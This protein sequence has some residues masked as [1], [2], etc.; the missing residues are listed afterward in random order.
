MLAPLKLE[1]AEIED[2]RELIPTLIPQ[3]DESPDHRETE[4]DKQLLDIIDLKNQQII[5]PFRKT[6]N[7]FLGTISKTMI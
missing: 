2:S 3:T 1:N 6:K 4:I 7:Y 5:V